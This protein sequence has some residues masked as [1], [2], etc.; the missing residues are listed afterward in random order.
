VAEVKTPEQ[1]WQ[2]TK[3]I[4]LEAA[5]ETIGYIKP[6]KKK[7]GISTDT[8]TLILRQKGKRKHRI[9]GFISS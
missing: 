7:G 1:L 9:L 6:V 8:F 5:E 4:L 3:S 2:E